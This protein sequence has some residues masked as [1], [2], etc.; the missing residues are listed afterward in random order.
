M[1]TTSP[2][3]NALRLSTLLPLMPDMRRNESFSFIVRAGEF[4]NNKVEVKVTAGDFELSTRV[5]NLIIDNHHGSWHSEV[6]LDANQTYYVVCVGSRCMQAG[7]CK[8][9]DDVRACAARY[10]AGKRKITP[11]GTA[12][13]LRESKER[14]KLLANVPKELTNAIAEVMEAN[15][16]AIEQYRAGNEKA[17]N[18]LVGQVM[19][20][21][22]T[23]AAVIKQLLIQFMS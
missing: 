21:H 22:K 14:A 1:I 4:S 6:T 2:A 23:D 9:E 11:P 18:A 15:S 17:V 19:R 5:N 10:L 7:F 20:K 8:T 3:K 12:R 16:K 13:R